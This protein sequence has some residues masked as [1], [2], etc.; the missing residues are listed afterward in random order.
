MT[1]RK[2]DDQR[3]RLVC[4]DISVYLH[5]QKMEFF[6]YAIEFRITGRVCPDC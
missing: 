5:S 4:Q 6:L 3:L 1:E 2:S